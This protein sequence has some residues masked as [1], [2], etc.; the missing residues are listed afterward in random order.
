MDS[1]AIVGI[2]CRFQGASDPEAFWQLLRNKVD[3]IAEVPSDR[4]NINA[5][6]NPNAAT[7]GKMNTRWGDFWNRLID[8]MPAS[9]EFHPTRQN[10]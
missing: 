5:Y 10:T 6:Y 2:G 8:S 9:S 3:A 4:W 1:I 7:P